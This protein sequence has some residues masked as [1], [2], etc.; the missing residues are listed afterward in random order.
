MPRFQL[1]SGLS[2][3]GFCIDRDVGDFRND[4]DLREGGRRH[5]FLV[6]GLGT[7]AGAGRFYEPPQRR[8]DPTENEKR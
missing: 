8:G 1:C 4:R 7:P 5:P 6:F 2:L 3:F